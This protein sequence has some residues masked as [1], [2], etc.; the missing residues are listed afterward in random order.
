MTDNIPKICPYTSITPWTID[1]CENHFE[2]ECFFLNFDTQYNLY[3]MYNNGA[4]RYCEYYNGLTCKA[5]NK[6]ND[7]EFETKI[8]HIVEG[9]L[10]D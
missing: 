4:C 1:D 6:P 8:K 5:G 3:C 2:G 9:F 7:C 10:L